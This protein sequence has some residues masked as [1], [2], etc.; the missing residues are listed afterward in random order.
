MTLHV[1]YLASRKLPY[2]PELCWLPK[3]ILLASTLP[4]IHVWL[5]RMFV[6]QL[7][8][9]GNDFMAAAGA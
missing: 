7:V 3:F 8:S 5:H 9:A 2:V 6:A 4:M 1:W